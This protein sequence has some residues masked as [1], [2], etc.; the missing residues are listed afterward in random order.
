MRRDAE[1]AVH[2]L[3][4]AMRR[5]R[6][7]LTA[8]RH[9]LDR[10]AT[11]QVSDELRWAAG[12]LSAARDTEVLR[13]HLVGELARL[14]EEAVTPGA[15]ARL[16]AYFDEQTAQ[17]RDRVREAL[18]SGRYAELLDALERLV[19]RPPFTGQAN[20]PAQDVLE[21]AVRR[22]HR[23]LAREAGRLGD[24]APGAELDTGLHEVRKKAKRARYAAEAVE[25][26]VGKRVRRWRQDVKALAGTLGEHHDSVVAR[27]V[28]RGLAGEPGAFTFGVLHQRETERG[29]RLH[30]RFTEQWESLG[31]P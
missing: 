31:A 24:L 2:Q 16:T 4:V 5:T 19:A 6:S 9:V 1:D 11:R 17:G 15:K 29:Q 8:F 12:E 18:S 14:P 28:L 25:P 13:E 26:V 21:R 7:V 27:E 23:R 10:D 3:R 22:T 30:Q 20:E